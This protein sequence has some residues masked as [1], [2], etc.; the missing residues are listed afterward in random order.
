MP[1]SILKAKN[2][3]IS[4]GGLRAVH[5]FEI[6]IKEGELVGL[7]GPN[8]AGKTT[9]F[10]LLTGVYRPTE[11][12]FYLGEQLM[13]G[14]KTHE[15]VASGIARTFQ[16]IRLFKKMTVMENVLIAF[17]KDLKANLGSSLL[18]TASFWREEESIRKKARDLLSVFNLQD[19]ADWLAGNLPYGQQ[20]KLEIARALATNAK[21]L[22]L[23]E[24]AAG[25]NPTETAELLEC[26]NTIRRR[27][28]ISI[29]LIEHDMS[30]VMNICERIVVIDYGE[31]IAQGLPEE[32]S[33][34]PKVIA[35]Y[36]GE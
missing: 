19:K 31:I 6:D 8:G 14:K 34:D 36:L 35:A 4:F 9:V 30:L 5:D 22:L 18:R 33:H 21:M 32:I 3:G 13:N 12:A 24:P 27:F 23:D 1:E 2:L 16:N 29:L 11:G 26:I 28:H 10:N 20:R 17:T 25:M 15:I 7:I